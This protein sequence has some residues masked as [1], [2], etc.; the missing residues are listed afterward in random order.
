MV[1]KNLKKYIKEQKRKILI[2]KRIAKFQRKIKELD[3]H[4]KKM[5]RKKLINFDKPL[6]C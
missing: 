5:R 6:K 2:R 1:L 3:K 4:K